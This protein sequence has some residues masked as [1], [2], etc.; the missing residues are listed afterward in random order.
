MSRCVLGAVAFLLL[1]A[2]PAVAQFDPEAKA[3]QRWHVV[4]KVQ[5]HPL[6]SA[7]F[8]EQLR[9]DVVAAVQPAFAALGTVEVIDL[10]DVPRDQWDA[11]WQQFED[12]GF[13]ALDAPRDLT[14]VK[15]HFLTLEYR[16]GQY[17]LES[18]QYDGFAGMASPLVRKQ[19]VRA[20]ELVG[21][22]AGLMLERDL[23]L[24]GSI[25]VVLAKTADEV[26]VTVRG[27]Q[28]GPIDRLV[29][30]GDVFK[31]T[32]IVKTNR[33]GP[34]PV[35][36]ASGKR[37]APPPGTVL[38]PAM[39]AN[40][41][42]L[43]LLQVKE[44]RKDGTIQC[45]VL[46]RYENP[47]TTGRDV[48]GY[49]CMKL[50]TVE[51]PLTVKLVSEH[52]DSQ[53]QDF[54]RVVV[55]ASERG[56]DAKADARDTLQFK[57]KE[58]VFR[59]GRELKNVACV[60][61]SLGPNTRTF[62]VPV[63]GPE[64]VALQFEVNEA[65]E[66][67][68]A[69]M[70]NLLAASVRAADAYAAQKVCF[71]ATTAL[72]NEQK[73]ARALQR[74]KGGLA[75]GDAADKTLTDDLARLKEAPD[76]SPGA[77]RVVAAIETKLAALRQGNAQLEKHVKLLE[78]VVAREDNPALALTDVL[79]EQI[80]GQLGRGE[81]DEAIATYDHMARVCEQAKLDDLRTQAIANRDKLKAEWAPK[82]EAHKKAR[83]YLLKTWPTL[84]TIPEIHGSLKRIEAEV[85]VCMDKKDRYAL[86]KLLILF[87]AATG[88]L[89]DLFAPLDPTADRALFDAAKDAGEKLA[90][91]EI[92]ITE[93]VNKKE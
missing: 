15:T 44:V 12:K 66:R 36:S 2:T 33:P 45:A 77:P 22:T 89:N 59:S 51:A 74:A 48:L 9:R 72:I 34:P 18:R 37:E 92:K 54:G 14:G 26:K 20:P 88:K 19:S 64:P 65:L 25:D 61:V 21:R 42:A 76:L 57:D 63:L 32:Q 40:V 68:A 82:D 30:V 75:A 60:T 50:G 23:G 62:P 49:R 47:A 81:V 38:P 27:G 70:R 83:E 1:A 84:G 16:D 6:L 35:Y 43:T 24:T 86:R 93:F 3:R 29:K 17:H 13:A 78:A 69:N 28:L 58:G 41:R 85:Q 91:L 10:A 52:S 67:Q 5:P 7:A 53:K 90:A 31:M 56:F 73:N 55:R 4:L 71:D 8:R 79:T 80:A 46:S 39:N 11:L 87:N